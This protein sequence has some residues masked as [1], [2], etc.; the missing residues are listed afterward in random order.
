MENF[1]LQGR[2]KN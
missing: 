2:T 1:Q